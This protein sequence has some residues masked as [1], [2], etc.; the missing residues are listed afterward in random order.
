MD[1]ATGRAAHRCPRIAAGRELPKARFLHVGQLHGL[2][3]AL[4]GAATLRKVGLTIASLH[5]LRTERIGFSVPLRRTAWVCTPF[6]PVLGS[7]GRRFPLHPERSSLVTGAPGRQQA[8]Q[9]CFPG[10]GLPHQGGEEA[11]S[12]EWNIRCGKRAHVRQRGC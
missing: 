4:P 12:G 3:N 6:S 9:G 7:S 10:A 11:G 2:T 1:I 5:L 8:G